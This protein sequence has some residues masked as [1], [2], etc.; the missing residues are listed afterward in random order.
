MPRQIKSLFYCVLLI[1]LLPSAAWAQ[2]PRIN[3]DGE[4]FNVKKSHK[5]ASA[6]KYN[7][8][9][10]VLAG[11]TGTLI[12]PDL[13]LTARHN[14]QDIDGRPLFAFKKSGGL[15]RAKLKESDQNYVF[16][17]KDIDKPVFETLITEVIIFGKPGGDYLDGSD[18]A[19]CILKKKVPKK[20]ARPMSIFGSAED[21][22][23]ELGTTIGYGATVHKGNLTF[24]T[25]RLMGKNRIDFYGPAYLPGPGRFF[26]PSTNIFQT[27]FDS[28]KDKHNNLNNI[29]F[30]GT[31][32]SSS[33]KPVKLE[34]T[35]APGD[36]GGPLIVKRNG[37]FVIIGVLSGGTDDAFGDVSHWTG[38]KPFMGQINKFIS[39]SKKR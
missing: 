4:F 21:A 18:V 1:S 30:K 10:S 25:L 33:K 37:K 31:T 35:T 22:I 26:R 3:I 8:V 15:Y 24:N 38:L 5:L 14:V 13:V 39:E 36:S 7:A 20:I 32:Y 29:T 27:D 9:C 23:G 11:G 6:N 19:L 17:G 34:V 2:D 16:F 28:G 12:A